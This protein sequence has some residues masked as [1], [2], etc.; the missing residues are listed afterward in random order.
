MQTVAQLDGSQL[1][2]HCDVKTKMVSHWDV[3]KLLC[4]ELRHCCIELCCVLVAD[5]LALLFLRE[6]KARLLMRFIPEAAQLH[7]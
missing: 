7:A 4:H 2:P 5:V 1:A 3:L 6:F